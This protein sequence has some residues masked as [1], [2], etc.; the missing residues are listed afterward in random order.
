M[1]GFRDWEIGIEGPFGGMGG[2]LES[3]GFC[4]D[5][6]GD[7]VPDIETGGSKGSFLQAP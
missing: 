7:N 3:G 6:E 4:V 5:A 2:A 1:E